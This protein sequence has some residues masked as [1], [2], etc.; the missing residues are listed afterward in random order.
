MGMDKSSKKVSK[1]KST[2]KKGGKTSRK[3]SEKSLNKKSTKPK[4]TKKSTKKSDLSSTS[5]ETSKSLAT[6]TSTIDEDGVSKKVTDEQTTLTDTKID[7]STMTSKTVDD[8]KTSSATTSTTEDSKMIS[9]SSS[10][11]KSEVAKEMEIKPK[12]QPSTATE[13]A[14]NNIDD[15]T[16]CLFNTCKLDPDVAIKIEKNR[17]AIEQVVN[18]LR[19]IRPDQITGDIKED[20]IKIHMIARGIRIRLAHHLAEQE[21]KMMDIMMKMLTPTKKEMAPPESEMKKEMAKTMTKSDEEKS[22]FATEKFADSDKTMATE[23]TKTTTTTADSDG[24]SSSSSSSDSTTMN[25]TETK[26]MKKSLENDPL[27]ITIDEPLSKSAGEGTI[28][29]K[30]CI[31]EVV[32]NVEKSVS[33]ND[34]NSGGKTNNDESD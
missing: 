7:D 10:Q 5:K 17:Q 14:K 3:K 12:T 30:V 29:M 2:I 1:K 11:P 15:Q 26:V 25:K 33:D 22:K 16:K 8:S 34:D 23:V 13:M 18:L 4:L 6:K 32:E 21:K 27:K 19:E 9:E 20:L 24:S 31:K 28:I